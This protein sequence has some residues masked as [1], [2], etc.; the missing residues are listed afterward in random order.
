LGSPAEQEPEG[1][2]KRIGF[3]PEALAEPNKSLKRIRKSQRRDCLQ[4]DSQASGSEDWLGGCISF[5]GSRSVD[6]H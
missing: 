3:L 4:R 5:V 6:F 2:K 1:P